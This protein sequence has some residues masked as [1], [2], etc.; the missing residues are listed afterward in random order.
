M[1][2]SISIIQYA[3]YFTSF[4]KRFILHNSAARYLRLDPG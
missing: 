2:Y 1:A 4:Q 3:D